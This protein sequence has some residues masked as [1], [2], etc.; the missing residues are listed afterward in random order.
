MKRYAIAKRWSLAG[1]GLLTILVASG[2][3]LADDDDDQ[4]GQC[5]LQGSWMG[6]DA[7]GK[8]YFV[9]THSGTTSKSGTSMLE[10][11][12]FD[13]TLGGMFSTAT[14]VSVV[15]GV[16]EKTGN[17]TFGW[18]GVGLIV[19]SDG[20]TLYLLKVAAVNTFDSDCDTVL[21]VSNTTEMFMPFENPFE[22]TPF[23]I[24]YGNP[25]TAMRMKVDPPAV[26]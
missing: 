13:L 19:D 18:T 26:P 23:Y 2:P 16:W 11:P 8:A 14:K 25:H 9:A 21:I 5:Q 17:R 15:R 1:L 6:Y 10:V 4:G 7:A 22:D 24:H 3:M 12:G 20:N